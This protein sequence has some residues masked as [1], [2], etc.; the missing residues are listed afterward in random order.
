MIHNIM[1]H[2]ARCYDCGN[3]IL[4]VIKSMSSEVKWDEIIFPDLAGKTICK[5]WRI[6][7]EKTLPS[8]FHA[9]TLKL[10]CTCIACNSGSAPFEYTAGYNA[11]QC[12]KSGCG[13]KFAYMSDAHK[14]I[15]IKMLHEKSGGRQCLRM[16]CDECK[17]TGLRCIKSFRQ[18]DNCDATGGI[19]CKICTGRFHNMNLILIGNNTRY[20]DC[21]HCTRGYSEICEKCNGM[22]AYEHVLQTPVT[23]P[24]IYCK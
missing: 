16:D 22:K 20:L 18:C 23:I 8:L 6:G 1:I 13:H 2:S 14:Q 5:H 17:G 15:D 12:V 19:Q 9:S 24:C 3:G 4:I 11:F 7:I 21:D 10:T